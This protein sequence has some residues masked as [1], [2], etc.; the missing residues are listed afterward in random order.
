MR[1]TVCIRLVAGMLVLLA[2][3]S[4]SDPIYLR[5]SQTDK[6]AQ[7]GPYMNAGIAGI[8]SA[9]VRERDCIVDYQR[10]GFERVME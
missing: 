9:M 2:G 4:M 6:K 3:C 8:Q 7:C 5:H 10:Q 1:T